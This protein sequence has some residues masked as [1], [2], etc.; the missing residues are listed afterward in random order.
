MQID[1]LHHNN[2][3]KKIIKKRDSGPLHTSNQQKGILKK[4]LSRSFFVFEIRS[5]YYKSIMERQHI[6]YYEFQNT[7][8]H[9]YKNYKTLSSLSNISVSHVPVIKLS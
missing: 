5:N 8:F 3:H 4:L 9:V 6:C 2:G 7:L 1:S